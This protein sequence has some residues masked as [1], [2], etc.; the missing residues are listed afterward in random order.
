LVAGAILWGASGAIALRLTRPLVKLVDLTRQ[1]GDGNLDAD[2]GLA[3][4]GHSEFRIIAEAVADMAARIR[5]QLDDQRELLAAVSHE[6]RTPLGHMRALVDIARQSGADAA[7]V[8]ELEAEIVALDTM[9]DQLLASSRVDFGKLDARPLDAVELGLRALERA[10][11]D[12]T[13]LDSDGER[14]GV[15]ADAALVLQALANLLRNAKEHA[16]GATALE[17]RHRDADVSW[18]VV[19]RGPGFGDGASRAFDAFARGAGGKPRAGS[20]GLGLAL[21]RRI[22]RAHGGDAAAADDPA[23]GARV[24]LTLPRRNA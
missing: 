4:F 14:I 1:I 3:R 19:D 12:P 24:T 9:V 8:G 7:W 6:L 5:K 21:V 2:A 18:S 13:L 17:I 11:L 15:E 20:L 10:G 23:G 16:G 22:A